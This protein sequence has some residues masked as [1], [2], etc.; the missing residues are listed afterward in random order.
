MLEQVSGLL[1]DLEGLDVIER[2]QVER[3]AHTPSVLQTT[4]HT[5]AA[6]RM[7]LA[8]AVGHG[9]RPACRC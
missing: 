6:W 1:V 5:T 9:P 2:F 3:F 8:G 4:T 7:F